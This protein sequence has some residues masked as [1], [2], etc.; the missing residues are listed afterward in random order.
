[1]VFC[2]IETHEERNTLAYHPPPHTHTH[3]DTH[4]FPP[5]QKRYCNMHGCEHFYSFSFF[6]VGGRGGRE[7]DVISDQLKLMVSYIIQMHYDRK[8]SGNLMK[9]ISV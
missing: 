3:T 4:L 9:R 8:P 1:M 5:K 7:C 6:M 2:R